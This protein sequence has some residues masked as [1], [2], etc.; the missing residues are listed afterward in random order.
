MGRKATDKRD[1]L[2]Q[3]A[4]ELFHRRGINAVSIAEI[5]GNAGVPPGNVF[6]YFRTKDELVRA[7]VD[8][9]LAKIRASQA[10]MLPG[11]APK[12]R[13]QAFLDHSANRSEIY[14][15]VGCPLVALARDLRQSGDDLAPL[16]Q[17]LAGEQIAWIG[18]LF[19]QG[20]LTMSEARRRGRAMLAVL[21]GGFQLAF[22]LRDPDVV[23]ECVRELKTQLAL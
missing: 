7:V 22:T 19:R 9:W 2:V 12:R 1:R 16:A 21:Q 11:E 6:Y 13:L 10:A 15:S 20:G 3:S 8:H 23:V 14:A 17:V 4:A 18:Q 5:A